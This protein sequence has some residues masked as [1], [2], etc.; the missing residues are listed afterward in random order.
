MEFSTFILT[1]FG[2]ASPVINEKIGIISLRFLHWTIQNE[3]FKIS[4]GNNI[5]LFCPLNLMRSSLIL[6]DLS[7]IMVDDVE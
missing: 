1:N 5:N 6:S 3:V 7:V 4:L 2:K